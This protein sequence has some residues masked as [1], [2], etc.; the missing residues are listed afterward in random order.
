MSEESYFHT[1]DAQRVT[2]DNEMPRYVLISL[3][4]EILTIAKHLVTEPLEAGGIL[5]GE[6]RGKH[7]RVVD[8]T[9]PGPNDL[10]KE[11]RFERRCKSHQR[12]LE[13]R[14]RDSN[15]ILTWVGEWHTHPH[16]DPNPSTL[17]RE[18]STKLTEGVGIS[19][20]FLIFGTKRS[21]YTLVDADQKPSRLK[22]LEKSE[23]GTLLGLN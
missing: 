4:D 12:H 5:I 16:G 10:R 3:S 1:T 18:A 9:L 21:S 15:E 17:D 13:R 11:H 20:F 23:Q 8:L 14:W 7:L 19:M 2:P 6:R 22:V